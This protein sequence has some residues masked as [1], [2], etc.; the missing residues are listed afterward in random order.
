MTVLE[1]LVIGLGLIWSVVMF[2]IGQSYRKDIDADDLERLRKE[3]Q[4]N[5]T[6]IENIRRSKMIA[7]QE[8]AEAKLDL[9]IERK[10]NAVCMEKTEKAEED[11]K[12]KNRMIEQLENELIWA[13]NN[14]EY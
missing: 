10:R 13:L 12:N 7:E 8:L 6:S 2:F 4:R 1:G 5:Q 9:Y 3:C 14:T 11:L